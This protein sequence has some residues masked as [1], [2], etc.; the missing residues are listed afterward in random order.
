MAD[1]SISSGK[2]SDNLGIYLGRWVEILIDDKWVYHGKFLAFDD[3]DMSLDD[4]KLGRTVIS[5]NRKYIIHEM[6]IK[7]KIRLA[8]KM[9]DMDILTNSEKLEKN[10]EGWWEKNRDDAKR[11][12]QMISELVKG[13]RA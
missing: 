5:R 10:I 9:N 1:T 3:R 6:I 4:M 13:N 7:E 12:S 2:N 11:I 8:G